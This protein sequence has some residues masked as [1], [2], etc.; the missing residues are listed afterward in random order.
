MTIF[1]PGSCMAARKRKVPGCAPVRQTVRPRDRPSCQNFR[2]R[3]HVGLCVA[4]V[5]AHRMQ[6]HRLSRQVLVD[7]RLAVGIA[8]R[9]V[10]GGPG[11]GAHRQLVVQVE[12]HRR[13]PLRCQQHVAEV[14]ENVRPN[15]LP[16]V[17]A[18]ERGQ[19]ALIDGDGEMIGPELSQALDERPVGR[20]RLA[21]ARPR[22]GEVNG[23]DELRKFLERLDGRRV[24]AG[25][26]GAAGVRAAL[27][28]RAYVRRRS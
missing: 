15:G 7:T 1:K 12:Q 2:E 25:A 22:L 24:V 6:L 13:V 8:A 11:V 5:D 28:L 21:Q 27:S 14:A 10:S 16:L 20:D 9:D 17:A 4:A 26:R 19:H 23:T 3:R 18:R